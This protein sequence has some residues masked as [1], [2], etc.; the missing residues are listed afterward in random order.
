[1]DGEA[2]FPAVA[3][4]IGNARASVYIVGWDVHSRMCLRPDAEDPRRWE[5]ARLLDR[6]TR[7]NP[8]LEVRVLSW[9]S[10]PL[11]LTDREF[12]P[13]MQFAFKTGPQVQFRSAADHP[14]GASHHQKLVVV[15]DR[16]AFV[17]GLDLTVARWDRREHA[18]ECALRRLPSGAS[19]PPFHDVALVMDGE[20]ARAVG[21]IARSRWTS[22]TGQGLAPPEVDGDPWPSSVETAF[23]EVRVGLARTGSAWNGRDEVREVEQL[24]T[25]AIAACRDVLYLENQYVT[26]HAVADAIEARL[27]EP[28]GPQ[29]LLVSPQHQFGRLEKAT[30]GAQR[31][32]LVRRL[33]A[34]DTENRLRVLAP[35]TRP[36]DPKEKTHAINV[37]AKVMVVDDRLLRVGSAN[38]SNRSMGLDSECDAAIEA[39]PGS[40]EAR[41]I[42]DF[43]NDLLAE[44]LGVSPTR[45]AETVRQ[46]GDLLSA[47]DRLRG[48]GG[49]TLVD[50]DIHA[51]ADR[52]L[53]D[54]AIFDP[55]RPVFEALARRAV[56]R[57]WARRGSARLSRVL[58]GF[59][60]ILG[61]GLAWV[62]TPL[63]EWTEPERIVALAR[64]LSQSPG[65]LVL[66]SA[67]FA[68]ASILMVPVTA[69]IVAS[70]L[71]FGAGKGFAV[72]MVGSLVGA[73]M[74]YGV[75][76]VLWRD[77]VRQLAGDRL[78][79]LTRALTERGV[80]AVAA[81]RVVPVAPFTVVNVVAGTSRIQFLDFMLGTVVG[82]A[83]GIAALAFASDRVIAAV[84]NPDPTTLAVAALGVLL[85]LGVFYGLRKLLGQ[86][87]GSQAR[88]ASTP[89]ES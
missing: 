27:A 17:G 39:M 8:Q 78:N 51:D 12:L 74:A 83:P 81:V 70:I 64:P 13:L 56:P 44:H 69:L 1:M 66:S 42:I 22:A 5:L 37:H 43:R 79:R 7:A 24:Y 49:R 53:M 3:E 9:D 88:K 72:G 16:V 35:V 68:L 85:L 11:Y 57:E 76:R 33:R 67:G 60:A 87:A 4:A 36:V 26:S 38:L 34:A 15:D 77:T 59:L 73:A 47:V 58:G 40:P 84:R 41:T 20:A 82:M 21:E 30:L 14:V 28:G 2:Y 50:Y 65:G 29:V 25:D 6:V 89:E 71:L 75:G 86:V 52:E 32:D 61:L 10:A 31:A 46:E 63:S 55:D 19:Y 45:V 48:V 23:E 54:E 62:F 18:P 80:L